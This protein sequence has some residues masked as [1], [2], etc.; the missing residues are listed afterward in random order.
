MKIFITGASGLIGKHLIQ[1]LIQ[2]GHHIWAL[3]RKK[4]LSSKNVQWVEGDLE[5]GPLSLPDEVDAVIHL[6]GEGVAEKRWSVQQREKLRS[7]RIQTSKN[8]LGSL[9]KP[10]A[11]LI[12][13]SATGFYGACGA[14]LIDESHP[15]GSDF[16]AELCKEWEEVF[17]TEASLQARFAGTRFVE[18]RFIQL[19]FGIVLAAQGG[20][21]KK[22]LP[23]FKLGLG[24]RLGKGEQGM[25]WIH[26]QDATR[27]IQHCLQHQDLKGP[28]NITAPEPVS[29]KEFTACLAKALH[30]PMGPPVPAVALKLVLGEMADLLLSGAMVLPKKLQQSGFE[31]KHPSLD[32]CLEDIVMQIQQNK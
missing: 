10:P 23:V 5:R 2:A 25:S 12:S 20:A 26:L 1:E 24:G 28:V 32:H 3:S 6:A 22:M 7:S 13:A 9:Q 8:L 4:Q 16:L 19:R 30:R 11:V 14:E 17:Q 29:N 21:L 15:P 18:T 31:F 27:A